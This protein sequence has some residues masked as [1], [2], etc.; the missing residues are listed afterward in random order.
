MNP[1]IGD[2]WAKLQRNADTG[3]IEAWHPLT[4]HCADVAAVMEALLRVPVIRSRLATLG[5]RKTLTEVDT[6]RLCVLA[7]LHDAGKVNHG[8]QAKSDLNARGEWAGHVQEIIALLFG[9]QWELTSLAVDALR[10][11]E[12]CSWFEGEESLTAYLAA[13][14]AHHGSPAHVAGAPPARKAIWEARAERGPMQGLKALLEHAKVWFPEA[15]DSATSLPSNE[16]F[17]H[18]FTGLLMLADWIASDASDQAFPY[19]ED[20]TSAV[21]RMAFARG[22]AARVVQSLGLDPALFR[23]V[24]EGKRVSF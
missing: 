3:A 20:G 22:R 14:F 21:Q 2:Y 5:D 23:D 4:H 11:R 1:P 24:L 17:V 10:L 6:A 15:F 18:G 12:L 19:S 16:P 8:F 9:S 7:A 13:A